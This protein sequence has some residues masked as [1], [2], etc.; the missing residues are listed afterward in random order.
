[1]LPEL[2][3]DKTQ[4]QKFIN[5]QSPRDYNDILENIRK[6]WTF[7]HKPFQKNPLLMFLKNHILQSGH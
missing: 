3:P 4:V 6:C 1:M 7:D 5:L 2:A